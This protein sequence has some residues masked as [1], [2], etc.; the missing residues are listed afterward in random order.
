MLIS[1][2]APKGTK[3]NKSSFVL[4]R[5]NLVI[6]LVGVAVF[7]TRL[8]RFGG[9]IRGCFLLLAG[10]AR[11]SGRIAGGGFFLAWCA[12]LPWLRGIICQGERLLML[13][14]LRAALL[15]A[16]GALLFA[17][18]ALGGRGSLALAAGEE[19]EPRGHSQQCTQTQ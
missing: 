3:L 5:P 15:L 8:A 4:L 7:L 17:G 11:L 19:N 14:W 9:R 2:L 12:G 16:S 18:G 10:G 6:P 13:R 1:R